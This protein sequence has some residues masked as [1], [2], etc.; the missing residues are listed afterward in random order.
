MR[1]PLVPGAALVLLAACGGAASALE[2][3]P[4][5]ETHV[6]SAAAN[7]PPMDTCAPEDGVFVHAFSTSEGVTV[8]RMDRHSCAL[9]PTTGD[10]PLDWLVIVGTQEVDDPSQLAEP[11]TREP[12]TE[13]GEI[14]LL[15]RRVAWSA[16][17]A[18]HPYVGEGTTTFTQLALTRHVLMAYVVVSDRAPAGTRERLLG[19]VSRMRLTSNGSRGDALPYE[20]SRAICNAGGIPLAVPVPEGAHHDR[21]WPESCAIMTG[22]MPETS[23]WALD[24]SAF[25]RTDEPWYQLL[26]AEPDGARRWFEGVQSVGTHLLE[27]GTITLLGVPTRWYAFDAVIDDAGP[28]IVAVA[29]IPSGDR[30]VL[31][32]ITLMPSERAS[33]PA[34]LDVLSRAE[35]I[36]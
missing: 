13:R 4:V 5:S 21:H 32:T 27:E 29:R 36:D 20:A 23:T 34:L 35:R 15:G 16:M 17:R 26:T 30:T 33:L 24:V 11:G 3:T 14:E 19:I 31:A 2:T 12:I 6:Q 18:G 10:E 8:Q 1:I 22:E 7:E 9:L 28:R 25:E